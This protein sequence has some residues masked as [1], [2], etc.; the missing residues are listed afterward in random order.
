MP[1]VAASGDSG[2]IARINS[3]VQTSLTT[4]FLSK[5]FNQCS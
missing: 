3:P 2:G 4:K 5:F 1:F